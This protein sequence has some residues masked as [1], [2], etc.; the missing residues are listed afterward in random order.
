MAF[1]NDLQSKHELYTRFEQKAD[2]KILKSISA[3]V[4]HHLRKRWTSTEQQTRVW[5]WKLD[6]NL[7]DRLG[8]LGDWLY[9]AEELLDGNIAYTDRHE[10]MANNIQRKLEE[11][12]VSSR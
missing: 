1:Q 11:H 5:L 6:S 9:R 3:D 4:W 7:P 2:A 10:D 8:H 12:R